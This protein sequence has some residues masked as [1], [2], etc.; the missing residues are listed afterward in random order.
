MMTTKLTLVPRKDGQVQIGKLFLLL[1]LV[2]LLTMTL[3]RPFVLLTG[4]LPHAEVSVARQEG[5]GLLMILALAGTW[6]DKRFA[7][8]C[9][10]PWPLGLAILWCWF[11]LSWSS[12]I[13]VSFRQLI[14]T[15]VVLWLSFV[16]IDRLGTR[17]S[18][19]V[20]R[21]IM[22]VLLVANFSCIILNPAFGIHDYGLAWSRGQWRG[23]M[24]HKNIAGSYAA[25]TILLFVFH[26]RR[27]TRLARY[28]VAGGAAVLLFFTQS[29][30]SMIGV[31]VALACGAL[32]LAFGR[33][34][35]NRDS[36]AKRKMWS[37]T[38]LALGGIAA[39]GVLVLT[40]NGN[41]LLKITRD[42]QFWSGRSQ[43]WQPMIVSYLERPFSGTGYGAFWANTAGGIGEDS[44]R[45]AGITQGHNGYLDL[46]VQVGLPGLILMLGAVIAW[47]V[48]I[49]AVTK[50]A[51][52]STVA[53]ASAL[54]IFYLLNNLTETS[55]LDGD[56]IPHVFAMLA[57]AMLAGTIRRRS[58]ATEIPMVQAHNPR[59][60][61]RR[62]GSVL[63]EGE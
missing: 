22:L 36:G 38:G 21:G 56:Q 24:A 48:A 29:R 39:L 17:R 27:S 9:P 45:L 46:A 8:L 40:L 25:I 61:R 10:V 59:V 33:R 50:R 58:A 15:S 14:L 3:S 47:P 35:G 1:V 2:G 43:I 26:G 30:T 18:L 19:F 37:R 11:S 6:I 52:L 34:L 62:S 63:A 23:I 12:V 44:S 7:R 51:D 31:I 20:M 42:P 54:L 4:V 28:A 57:L 53:L 41:I 16:C 32:L 5:Y 49:V 13:A 55:L 60:R